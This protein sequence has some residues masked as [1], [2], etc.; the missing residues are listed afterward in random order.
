MENYISSKLDQGNAAK[1]YKYSCY[2]NCEKLKKISL[3]YINDFYKQVIETEEFEDLDREF[4][5]EIVRFCKT[6]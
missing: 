3:Y 1:I 6:K 5:L 4:M 2:Y